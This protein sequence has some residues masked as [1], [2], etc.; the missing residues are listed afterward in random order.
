MRDCSARYIVHTILGSAIE[1]RPA[2]QRRF[3]NQLDNQTM[4][5]RP[6]NDG[7]GLGTRFTHHLSLAGQTRFFYLMERPGVYKRD[8]RQQASS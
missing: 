1:T 2:G 6:S 5:D 3:R 4:A 8:Y 7:G